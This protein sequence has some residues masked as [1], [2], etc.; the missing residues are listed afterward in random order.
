MKRNFLLGNDDHELH[1]RAY[2]HKRWL[3][4]YYPIVFKHIDSQARLRKMAT[5]NNISEQI[6]QLVIKH[7]IGQRNGNL[8]NWRFRGIIAP[9]TPRT[10][11]FI[12]WI[13]NSSIPLYKYLN[14][15]LYT[16]ETTKKKRPSVFNFPPREESREICSLNSSVS[17]ANMILL[18][19]YI[20]SEPSF[21]VCS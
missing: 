1:Q 18:Q 17:L 3:T 10:S 6:D 9:R 16:N 5:K 2:L 13:V 15:T 21:C 19:R 12:D 11:Y 7:F 20:S 14:N 4:G 8:M